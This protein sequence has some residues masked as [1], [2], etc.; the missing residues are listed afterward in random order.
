MK[1]FP[2]IRRII[3]CAILL[4]ITLAV[5]TPALAKDIKYY[6]SYEITEELLTSRTPDTLIVEKIVGIVMNENGDGRALNALDPE[7]NYIS[8][9]GL[10]YEPMDIVMTLVTYNPDTQYIDDIIVRQDV[11]IGTLNEF[12]IGNFTYKV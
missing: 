2:K 11:R 7:F 3:T 9:S 6:D 12:R 4:C 5:T 10:G 1:R 8:Y